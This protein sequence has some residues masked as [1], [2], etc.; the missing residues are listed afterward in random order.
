MILSLG[1]RKQVPGLPD[2]PLSPPSALGRPERSAGLWV[3]GYEASL[4]TNSADPPCRCGLEEA[5]PS[6]GDQAAPWEQSP[7][8]PAAWLDLLNVEMLLPLRLCNPVLFLRPPSSLTREDLPVQS[9]WLWSPWLQRVGTGMQPCVTPGGVLPCRGASGRVVEPGAKSGT[10]G[11]VRWR[12]GSSVRACTCVQ[13]R[14]PQK[15]VYMQRE[16][17][18]THT[19]GQRDR[20][21]G[22]ADRLLLLFPTSGASA[23]TQV[24]WGRPRVIRVHRAVG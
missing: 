2:Q 13:P 11:A 5:G 20:E 16:T 23:F 6:S 12:K 10:C 18:E 9:Q 1:L 15:Q 3:R 19:C 7:V 17:E 8:F 24:C 14:S 22:P 4:K 21:R